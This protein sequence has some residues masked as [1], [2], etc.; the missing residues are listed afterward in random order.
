M[1]IIITTGLI[2]DLKSIDVTVEITTWG[3]LRNSAAHD[4][5]D[6]YDEKEV[7]MMLE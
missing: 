1:V 4:H 2:K 5:Y 7:H 6:N 3:D